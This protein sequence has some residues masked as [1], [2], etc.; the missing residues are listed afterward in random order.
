MNLLTYI[1]LITVISFHVCICLYAFGAFA[2]WAYTS[3]ADCPVP[4]LK[5]QAQFMHYARAIDFKNC[6]HPSVCM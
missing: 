3:C 5:G 6:F 2:P 1:M 4:N